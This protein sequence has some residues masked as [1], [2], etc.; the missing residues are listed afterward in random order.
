MISIKNIEESNRFEFKNLFTRFY[1]LVF[2][3]YYKRGL[4]D[5]SIFQTNKLK[6]LSK[7]LYSNTPNF[8]LSY[9]YSL[10]RYMYNFLEK[11]NKSYVNFINLQPN[12]NVD[13]DILEFNSIIKVNIPVK[14]NGELDLLIVD[15]DQNV[16]DIKYPD[17]LDELLLKGSILNTLISFPNLDLK[18]EIPSNFNITKFDF[19]LEQ[20][21]VIVNKNDIF[22]SIIKLSLDKNSYFYKLKKKKKCLNIII[23]YLDDLSNIPDDTSSIPWLIKSPRYLESRKVIPNLSLEIWGIIFKFMHRADYLPFR[24][25]SKELPHLDPISRLIGPWCNICLKQA[26]IPVSLLLNWPADITNCCYIS[27]SNLRRRYTNINI[28]QP[29]EYQDEEF[30]EDDEEFCFSKSDDYCSIWPIPRNIYCLECAENYCKKFEDELKCPLG[31]C[32]INKPNSYIYESLSCGISCLDHTHSFMH[33]EMD[34]KG[35][36]LTKCPNCSMECYSIREAKNHYKNEKCNKEKILVKTIL[37]LN[38]EKGRKSYFYK[39]DQNCLDLI[40]SHLYPL[41]NTT[42]YC[43][44]LFLSK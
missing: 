38:S 3:I 15:K 26:F 9:T 36:G 21:K 35:I 7:D 1:S 11:I 40:I 29:L 8:E 14:I 39:L 19:N 33:S 17:Q 5:I 12:L 32:V 23:S 34:K 41:T 24:R 18:S 6:V 44:V 10:N 28:K 31:C 2:S 4:E 16:I 30:S 22:K 13:E 20:I 27:M 43:V 25:L 42:Y 37:L